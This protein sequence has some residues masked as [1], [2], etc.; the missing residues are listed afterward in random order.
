LQSQD[1]PQRRG[2]LGDT[3]DDLEDESYDPN[4]PSDVDEGSKELELSS[5]EEEEESID[6]EET[7]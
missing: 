5:Q 3:S 1:T 2:E 6:L 4:K 7:L